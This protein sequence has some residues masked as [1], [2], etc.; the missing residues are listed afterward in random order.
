M[1]IYAMSESLR[2]IKKEL[3]SK[4]KQVLRHLIRIILYPNADAYNH[5]KQ[6]IV[7]FIAYTDKVK[8][9][10]KFPKKKLI[11]DALQ[12]QNDM[13]HQVIWQVKVTERDLEP[14]EID[15]NIILDS[16]CE[17]Q[18]WLAEELSKNGVIDPYEAYKVLD[19]IVEEANGGSI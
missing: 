17:Y 5:W 16:V 18:N 8:G 1:Y 10:S 9:K 13:I 19:R 14:A 15:E 11:L 2:D 7:A 6:E 4:G 3:S 12:S